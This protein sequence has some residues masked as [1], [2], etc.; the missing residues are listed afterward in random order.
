MT[1]LFSSLLMVVSTFN[2]MCPVWVQVTIYCW[3][4][5]VVPNVEYSFFT[6]RAP[7]AKASTFVLPLHQD[8]T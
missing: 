4:G 2:V 7:R 6:Y 3:D 1:V 5:Y 8:A